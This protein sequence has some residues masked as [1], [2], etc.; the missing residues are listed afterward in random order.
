YASGSAASVE[1]AGAGHRHGAP[2]R[3]DRVVAL[4]QQPNRPAAPAAGSTA[5]Q[6][7]SCRVGYAQ[8]ESVPRRAAG[9]TSSACWRATLAFA[10][11]AF[12]RQAVV[13]REYD[14][15]PHRP[16][17]RRRT[18]RYITAERRPGDVARSPVRA[19]RSAETLMTQA[20]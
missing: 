17:T 3:C 7:Q 13:E 5:S 20:A 10:V 1:P 16:L 15:S 11:R 18:A 14:R 19:I 8:A 9:G 2:E 6:F 4:V 12:G